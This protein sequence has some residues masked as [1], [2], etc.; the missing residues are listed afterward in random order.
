MAPKRRRTGATEE[1]AVAVVDAGAAAAAPPVAVDAAAVAAD[2]HTARV[3]HCFIK[4][5]GTDKNMS[6]GSYGFHGKSSAGVES[7]SFYLK[8][9]S[10]QIKLAGEGRIFV[11][12]STDGKTIQNANLALSLDDES[13][14]FC[15]GTLQPLLETLTADH[16]ESRAV[17][18]HAVSARI[19]V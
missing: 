15:K 12:T 8:V 4:F 17:P 1:T 13:A 9:E 18:R 2:A 7:M 10:S 14:A 6:F 11:S 19:R 16:G 5:L 3:A